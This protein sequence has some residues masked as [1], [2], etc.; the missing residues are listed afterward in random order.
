MNFYNKEQ[1][2]KKLEKTYQEFTFVNEDNKKA[3]I[4]VTSR[5][6]EFKLEV[7]K[8]EVVDYKRQVNLMYQY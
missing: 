8:T 2:I 3:E 1:L 5:G 6:K 7:K 4:I